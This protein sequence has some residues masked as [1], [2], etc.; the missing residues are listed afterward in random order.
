M[1]KAPQTFPSSFIS[2]KEH[3]DEIVVWAGARERRRSVGYGGGGGGGGGD[4]KRE[5]VGRR[6]AVFGDKV[7]EG[8]FFCAMSDGDVELVEVGEH[9]LWHVGCKSFLR[10][11][12]Q[13]LARRL[14]RPYLCFVSIRLRLDSTGSFVSIL[15]LYGY[16]FVSFGVGWL[17]VF[18]AQRI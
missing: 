15:I 10:G 1:E 11:R 18:L 2:Q 3:G 7:G 6:W 17:G 4:G 14:G 12:D 16:V 5:D 8:R 13:K 9:H